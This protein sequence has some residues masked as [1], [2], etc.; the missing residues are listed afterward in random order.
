MSPRPG[1]AALRLVIVNGLCL[2]IFCVR[3]VIAS[4]AYNSSF[5]LGE[6]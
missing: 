6:K 1:M 4:S 5:K 3:I 2:I